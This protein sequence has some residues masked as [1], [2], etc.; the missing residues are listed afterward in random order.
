M[1]VVYESPLQML[2]DSPSNYRREPESLAFLSSVPTVWDETRVLSAKVGEHI[3]VARRSGS[4]WY[5][6]ALTNWTARTLE[7]DLS[8]LGAGAFT[9][10]AFR[11]GLNADRV[12]VDYERAQLLLTAGDKLTLRLAPGGGFAAQIRPR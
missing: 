12:G 4:A 7:I 5:V 8:W 11:D 2:A 10:D 6:G 9:A 1:Y 3:V